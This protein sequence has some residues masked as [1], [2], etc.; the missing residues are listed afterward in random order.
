MTQSSS[1]DERVAL[2]EAMKEVMIM[3]Q[4]LGVTKNSKIPVM[5][6]VKN[7]GAFFMTRNI[8]TMSYTKHVDNRVGKLIILRSSKTDSNIITKN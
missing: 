2:S 5:V 1:E 7:K 4:L 8:T 6:R 3:I